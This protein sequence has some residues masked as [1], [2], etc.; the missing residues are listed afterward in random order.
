MA[1]EYDRLHR[2]RN[3]PRSDGY[4]LEYVLGCIRDVGSDAL[5]QRRVE[6]LRHRSR[7]D[8]CCVLLLRGYVP[9]D[10]R[11]HGRGIDVFR[12]S[13]AFTTAKIGDQLIGTLLVWWDGTTAK[14]WA[15]DTLQIAGTTQTGYDLGAAMPKVL[16][17]LG[18]HCRIDNTSYTGADL[19]SYDISIYDTAAHATTGGATGRLAKFS[20]ATTYSSNNPTLIITTEV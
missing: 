12:A 4:L 14:P 20:V 5:V 17:L 13:G 6:Q 10:C 16:G 1:R 3:D 19:V 11:Q 7:R 18:H 2:L 8:S 15:G 9:C